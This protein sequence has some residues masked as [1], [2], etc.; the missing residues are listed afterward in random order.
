MNAPNSFE[1][2]A[3]A[4]AVD[5]SGEVISEIIF[6]ASWRLSVIAY[7]PMAWSSQRACHRAIVSITYFDTRRQVGH[8]SEIVLRF[9]P[10]TARPLP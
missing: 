10:A 9:N 5:T 3:L 6:K 7:P 2:A 1:E 8:Y 4:S